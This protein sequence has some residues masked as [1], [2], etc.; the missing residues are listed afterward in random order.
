[1]SVAFGPIEW[2]CG[3]RQPRFVL[4][5]R[6]D[7][8]RRSRLRLVFED[9]V[10]RRTE[11]LLT[12]GPFPEQHRRPANPFARVEQLLGKW[13][14]PPLIA[15]DIRG[16]ETRAGEYDGQ[17]D[18]AVLFHNAGT[19]AERLDTLLHEAVGHGSGAKHRLNRVSLA[20]YGIVPG[21]AEDE[22]AIARL[23]VAIARH[24]IGA[25]H[26]GRSGEIHKLAAIDDCVR[27]REVARQAHR[28]VVYFFKGK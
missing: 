10:L 12:V 3:V 5:L 21:A 23:T 14:S 20:D 25:V 7:N 13:P 6:G 2:I 18:R 11:T 9:R 17:K 8:R 24:R 22:E 28:A 16:H 1:M 4:E 27:I 19:L 15:L 26:F